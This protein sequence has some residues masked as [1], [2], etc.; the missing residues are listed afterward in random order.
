MLKKF[1]TKSHSKK[2]KHEDICIGGPT[3]VS[4]FSDGQLAVNAPSRPQS[5]VDL[6]V[7]VEKEDLKEMMKHRFSYEEVNRRNGFGQTP[8]H[9]ACSRP[10]M[11]PGIVVRAWHSLSGLLLHKL[12]FQVHYDRNICVRWGVKLIQRIRQ[13]GHHSTLPANMILRGC[14]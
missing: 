6:H 13:A 10:R 7:L 14:L 4:D 8:L 1:K 9:L 5:R 11:D 2:N 12:W 3:L